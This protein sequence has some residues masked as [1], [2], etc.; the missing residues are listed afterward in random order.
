MERP[1]YL[2]DYLFDWQTLGVLLEG[3][4]VVDAASYVGRLTRRE[5]VDAFL[6]GYGFDLE[7]PIVAAELFGN[8]QEA[9][10]FIRKYFLKEGNPEGLDLSLP[11]SFLQLVDIRQLFLMA[12]GYSGKVSPEEIQW[13][14]V[15][16]KVMHTVTHADKDLR[17][18]YLPTIQQQIFDRFYRYLRR[19]DQGQ[20]FLGRSVEEGIALSE[21]Q[22]KPLKSRESIILKLLHKA[23]YV[24]EELFDRVGLRIVTKNRLDALKVIQFLFENY[25]IIPQNIKPSRSH[26]SLLNLEKFRKHYGVALKSAMRGGWSEEQ[27]TKALEVA[28]DESKFSVEEIVNDNVNSSKKYEAI[29]FTCRQLIHYVN[30]LYQDLVQLK[31]LSKKCSDGNEVGKKVNSLN[32]SLLEKE[33]KFFYP[34]EIQVTDAESHRNN[35]QGEAAHSGYKKV[36]QK[37]A[38]QRLFS[39]FIKS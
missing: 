10:Q 14:S 6:A 29:H 34:F 22:T 21:F 12:T 39:S 2:A 38:M 33:V 26:N 20:L 15:I 9:L 7:N 11:H 5:D 18:S 25:I 19:D 36:Q 13:A 16:L 17:H 8:Y 35:T 4:S 23:E 1:Q 37:K 27:F 28:L 30:P 32:L 3:H 24:A 31:R